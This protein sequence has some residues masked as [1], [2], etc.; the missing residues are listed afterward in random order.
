M[1]S[2]TSELLHVMQFSLHP[3]IACFDFGGVSG[4]VISS[5]HVHDA[6]IKDDVM[7][8]EGDRELLAIMASTVVSEELGLAAA[9]DLVT[10]AIA[11][12]LERAVNYATP[13]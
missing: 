2:L 3:L 11:T 1:H 5:T 12:R 13:N 7:P 8:S 6:G 10:Q 4:P 9:K